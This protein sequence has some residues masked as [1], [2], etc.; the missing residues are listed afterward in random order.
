MAGTEAR[1]VRDAGED[2]H[3]ACGSTW[4][5]F[6]YGYLDGKGQY[7]TERIDAMIL[8]ESSWRIDPGG[9]HLGLAQ[10]DPG[11][12]AIVSA[13]TGLTD[14]RDPYA[15]GYNVAVWSGMVSP[16]TTAGWPRCWWAW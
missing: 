1:V 15:Q 8:C 9:F 7:S 13:I 4:D 3:P 14:W 11:T 12:W 6:F 16:G 2:S 5:C 10:F